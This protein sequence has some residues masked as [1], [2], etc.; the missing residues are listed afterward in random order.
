M[1]IL[2]CAAI[3]LVF[4]L[5]GLCKMCCDSDGL[6]H[7]LASLCYFIIGVVFL[8]LYAVFNIAIVWYAWPFLT[9][10]TLEDQFDD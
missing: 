9:G 3:T 8:V 6:G 1:I 5:I 10:N 7:A 4:M 2:I